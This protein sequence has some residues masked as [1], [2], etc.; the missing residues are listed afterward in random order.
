MVT[1]Q[2]I[3]RSLSVW[4]GDRQIEPRG[5]PGRGCGGQRPPVPP[6]RDEQ[7][8]MLAAVLGLSV[9]VPAQHHGGGN[10][11]CFH[12]LYHLW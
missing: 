6:S 5:R 4:S 3:L 8:A 12:A 9:L 1:G 11:D 7:L 2:A 10:T